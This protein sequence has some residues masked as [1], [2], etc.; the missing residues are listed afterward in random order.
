[1][2]SSTA[3]NSKL[4]LKMS[5]SLEGFVGGPNG[6]ADWIFRTMG[7]STAREWV[8]DSLGNAGVH[9]TGSRT[10][11]DIAAFLP[12]SDSP[13]A[14]AM[15]DILKAIFSRSG[16]KDSYAPST[17]A[18]GSDLDGFTPSWLNFCAWPT[19]LPRPFE[20]LLLA[21]SNAFCICFSL[22]HLRCSLVGAAQADL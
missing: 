11:Y 10:Y 17:K 19:K 15:N 3:T 12:Y 8:V 13:L 6:E 2:A 21:S 22:H 9:I 14:P 16:I 4:V 5:V 18:A 1:M 7:D 20:S